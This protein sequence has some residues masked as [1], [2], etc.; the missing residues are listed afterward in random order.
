LVAAITDS[1]A[2][3]TSSSSPLAV[4]WIARVLGTERTEIETP[5]L[6]AFA[7]VS[8]DAISSTYVP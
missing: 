3:T 5:V 4:T 7:V 6:R 2:G 8:L 1:S